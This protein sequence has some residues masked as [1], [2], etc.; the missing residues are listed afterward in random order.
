VEIQETHH[1]DKE[2]AVL[3]LKI[4]ADIIGGRREYDSPLSTAVTCRSKSTRKLLLDNGADI[5]VQS[6]GRESAL[7]TANND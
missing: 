2:V 3:I 6:S 5:N 1:G 4:A 7:I